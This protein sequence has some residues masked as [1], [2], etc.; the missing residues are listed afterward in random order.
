MTTPRRVFRSSFFVGWR[1]ITT[2][3]A[4]VAAVTYFVSLAAGH[5]VPRL[6]MIWWAAGMGL[7]MAILVFLCPVYVSAEGIRSYNFY[8]IYSTVAWN[9]EMR[10]RR[11][12]LF[13]LRYI[14]IS[15]RANWTELW[16]P[17][18]L[19]DMRGFTEA[20][21]EFGGDEHPLVLELRG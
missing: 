17:L 3:C 10:T 5:P 4:I 19:S 7:A 14:V 13:G 16:V 18:F 6:P 2:A 11:H 21:A 9:A 20:V 8:G 1:W 12:N 15:S